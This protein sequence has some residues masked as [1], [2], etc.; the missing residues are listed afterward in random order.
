MKRKTT[1]FKVCYVIGVCLFL[2]LTLAPILWS[3][4]MSIT[5]QNEI[6]GNTTQYLPTNPT[7][8]HYKEL[9][10]P[11]NQQGKLFV[12]GIIN[13]L[14]ASAITLIIGIP[15]A[16]SCA[17][18]LSRLYFKGSMTIRNILLF[19]MAI[20]VFATIIPIYRIFATTN[21]LDNL[22]ALVMVYT[23][24]FLPVTVWLLISYFDTLPKELEE[25]AYVDG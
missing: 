21:L 19:T 5:P 16:I 6:M 23:T 22:L 10:S 13:S 8:E 17:Y 12:K 24:S 25:S 7:L 4:V 11:D 3:M 18:P 15:I 2:I 9:L 14:K 20:P 1:R